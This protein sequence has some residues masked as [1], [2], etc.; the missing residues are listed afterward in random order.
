[1]R[2]LGANLGREFLQ[3]VDV[4]EDPDAAVVSGEDEVIV[5]WMNDEIVERHPRHVVLELGPMLSAVE[6]QEQTEL[7][8]E[9]EQ[10]RILRILA[11]GV[12]RAI[13]RQIALDG[14]PRLPVVPGFE[15]VV[16][17]VAAAMIVGHEIDEA[18]VVARGLEPGDPR[19]LRQAG[20]LRGNIG[21]GG[22]LVGGDLNIAVVGAGVDPALPQRRFGE[23][24]ERGVVGHAVVERQSALVGGLAHQLQGAT[25]DASREIAEVRPGLAAIARSE[26]VT[27]PGIQRLRVVG[28]HDEGRVPVR[29]IGEIADEGPGRSPVA[30]LRRVTERIVPGAD[31]AT[32]TGLEVEAIQG[33]VLAVRVDLAAVGLGDAEET[34]AAI[35]ADPVL[36]ENAP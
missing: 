23:G 11:Q 33:E 15:D 25:I 31:D 9:I 12:E 7:G 4:V 2:G 35:R 27:H 8:T 28:R 34:V 14:G 19:R 6:G 10:V 16:R 13:L 18:G 30:E 24:G 5:A 26:E 20:D 29:G 3:G 21:E 32:F 1:M 36:V 17:V 22:A